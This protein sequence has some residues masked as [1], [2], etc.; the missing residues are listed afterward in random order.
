MSTFL[1]LNKKI[2]AVACDY[3]MTD[4]KENPIVENNCMKFPIGCGICLGYNIC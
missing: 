2:D 1:A 4:E 3:T